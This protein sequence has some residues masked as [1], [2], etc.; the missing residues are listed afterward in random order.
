MEP[1]EDAGEALPLWAMEDF[2]AR[3]DLSLGSTLNAIIG[4]STFP[5]AVS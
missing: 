2:A 4:A 1:P 5:A 3:V